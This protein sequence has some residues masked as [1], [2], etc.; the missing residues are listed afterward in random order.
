MALAGCSSDTV[1]ITDDVTV[2][3]KDG[4]ISFNGNVLQVDTYTGSTATATLA[5]GGNVNMML[6]EVKDLGWLTWNTQGIEEGAMDTYKKGKYFSEYLGTKVTVAYP[7]VEG[8]AYAVASGAT[9][10]SVEAD[11][12]ALY[13]MLSKVPFTNASVYVDFGDFVFGDG[14]SGMEVRPDAAVIAGVCKVSL[15]SLD[16]ATT[17][18]VINS[19]KTEYTLYTYTDSKYA[20]Y[21]YD[22]YLIQLALGLRLEDY[23]KFK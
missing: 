7:L 4:V 16:K 12:A 14:F 22:G 3:W 18:Y 2:E 10:G 15:G 6:D 19:G 1:G 9:S 17:P 8:E 5:T 21:T 13:D 11:V 23:V 20:Y